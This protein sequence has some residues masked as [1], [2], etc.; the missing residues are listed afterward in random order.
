MLQDVHWSSGLIG[1]FPTYSLGT[2][3]SA[4]LYDKAVEQVPS[5][6]ADMA[7]GEFAGLL[8][9]LRENIHRHGRKFEPPELIKRATGEPLQS[10]SY[11]L[12]LKTKFGEIYKLS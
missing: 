2:I 3:L 8:G 5:I 1:Y 9:W 11:M 12:Y 4:Q 10:R 7:R 6:P